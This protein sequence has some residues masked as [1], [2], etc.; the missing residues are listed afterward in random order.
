MSS[1][2][3]SFNDDLNG[4]RI[5]F[6]HENAHSTLTCVTGSAMTLMASCVSL[7]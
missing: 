5:N 1:R 4:E 6:R 7:G 2:I 3:L